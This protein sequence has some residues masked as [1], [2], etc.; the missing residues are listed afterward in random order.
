MIDDCSGMDGNTRLFV[1][2]HVAVVAHAPTHVGADA[3]DAV[4]VAVTIVAV[5]VVVARVAVAHAL[6]TASE[7]VMGPLRFH[8]SQCHYSPHVVV[9]SRRA[10]TDT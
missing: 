6:A 9:G 3:V 7:Q 2:V 4:D 8:H 10:R 5:D 1:S